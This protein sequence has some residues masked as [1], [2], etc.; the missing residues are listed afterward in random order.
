MR[1]GA[2]L[3]TGDEAVQEASQAQESDH[4]E[5]TCFTIMP[6]GGWFDQYYLDVYKPAIESAGLLPRR[7]DDLYRPGTIVH[8]IWD[9]TQKAKVI[10]ADLTGKNPNVFYELGLGHALAK[11]VILITESIEDVPFDLRALRVIDYDKNLPDWG[12]LLQKKIRASLLEVLE[13]PLASVLPAFLDVRES[14]DDT[15]VTKHQKEF[16]EIRQELELLRQEVARSQNQSRFRESSTYRRRTDEN[17]G[18]E[19]SYPLEPSEARRRIERYLNTGV[20]L[21]L[22]VAK[23]ADLGAPEHWTRRKIDEYRTQ[24]SLP[25]IERTSLRTLESLSEDQFEDN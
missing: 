12:A 18:S 10:L 2:K 15:S 20:P 14:Q 11:P 3:V 8:D 25:S 21:D 19:P 16:L 13:A 9:Y 17:L 22:I 6:F 1:D 7:A 23:L 4:R 24:D 5:E